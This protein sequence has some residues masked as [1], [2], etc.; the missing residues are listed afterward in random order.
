[1]CEREEFPVALE[2]VKLAVDHVLGG[3]ENAIADGHMTHNDLP[4]AFT[5]VAEV[6]HNLRN[7]HYEVGC[8]GPGSLPEVEHCSED[9][10]KGMIL[11]AL[12]NTHRD[13]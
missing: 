2:Q 1:M 6:Y 7:C 13:V 5:L 4:D 9:L 11:M 3:Y 10:L 12:I 8:E